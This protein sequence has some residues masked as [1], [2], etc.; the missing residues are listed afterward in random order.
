VRFFSVAGVDSSLRGL[1]GTTLI[2]PSLFAWP[3]KVLAVE[4]YPGL[5]FTGFAASSPDTFSPFFSIYRLKGTSTLR[6]ER[7]TMMKPTKKPES[8]KGRTKLHSPKK[9]E[10]KKPLSYHYYASFKGKTQTP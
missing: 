3:T 4:K 7:R 1:P 2:L 9:L 5:G 8:I 10:A 6:I